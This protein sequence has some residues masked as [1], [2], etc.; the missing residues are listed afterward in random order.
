MKINK[1]IYAGIAVLTLL[2]GLVL[3][4]CA[5]APPTAF[6]TAESLEGTTWAQGIRS[7]LVI[8]DKTSGVFTD[9]DD[10]ETAFTYTAVY[11]AQKRTFA[12]TINLND[13]RVAEFGAKR[14][15]IFG[16]MLSAKVLDSGTLQYRTSEQLEDIYRQKREIAEIAGKYGIEYVGLDF[17]TLTRNSDKLML[18]YD[19]LGL[20]TTTGKVVEVAKSAWKLHSKDGVNITLMS[21]NTMS[22]QYAGTEAVGSFNIRISGKNVTISNGTGAG[23]AFN[24]AYTADKDIDAQVTATHVQKQQAYA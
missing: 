19:H 5:S 9:S 18:T 17:V 12:G 16:W 21:I 23:A 2:F 11:D 3:T 13:G 6:E 24:G 10:K 15:G 22:G 7:I 20:H 1:S 8:N 14:Y 4:G